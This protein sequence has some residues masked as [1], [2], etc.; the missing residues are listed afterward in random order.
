MDYQQ[1]FKHLFIDLYI[2]QDCHAGR[3]EVG[4]IERSKAGQKVFLFPYSSEGTVGLR[5][6]NL[7]SWKKEEV[8][9]ATSHDFSFL[10]SIDINEQVA[11]LV[12]SNTKVL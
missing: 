11:K 5:H 6:N 3:A 7:G 9:S 10:L 4:K 2:F 1:T 12:T 8:E